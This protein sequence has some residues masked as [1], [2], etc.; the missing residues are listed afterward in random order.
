MTSIHFNIGYFMTG[1]ILFLSCLCSISV[2]RAIAKNSP[3]TTLCNSRKLFHQAD[4]VRSFNSLGCWIENQIFPLFSQC[5]NKYFSIQ[6][7]K[8][9]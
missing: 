9:F 1:G 5:K 4:L 7:Y 3:W 2:F 8:E 6:L